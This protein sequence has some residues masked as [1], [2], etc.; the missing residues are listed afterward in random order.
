MGCIVAGLALLGFASAPVM[1]QKVDFGQREYNSNCA[2]CH[3]KSGKGDGPYMGMVADN[4][5]GK[6]ITTL[7]K[8][9]GGV[10]PVQKVTETIDG[11]NTVKAH[12]PR[13]MPIWGAD[14][15]AR[16]QGDYM[17]V[18]YDPERY[19]QT[20]ILALTEYLYRLQVK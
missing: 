2:V 7:A 16:A 13:D 5:G 20:R 17:D 14:Y 12:G 11:R 15:L 6:D 19:V 3:G 4:Q 10:F 8:R 1:A 9:N 18:P